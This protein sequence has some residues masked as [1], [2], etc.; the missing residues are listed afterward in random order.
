MSVELTTGAVIAGRYR[1]ENIIGRG[2][3]GVMH[4]VTHRALA[5]EH[6]PGQQDDPGRSQTGT[7]FPPWHEFVDYYT[8]DAPSSAVDAPEARPRGARTAAQNDIGV[9]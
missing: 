2:G 7:G 5:P 4:L 1:L 6:D 8:A 3:M 9:G